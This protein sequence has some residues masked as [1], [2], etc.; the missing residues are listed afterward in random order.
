MDE[1]NNVLETLITDKNRRSYIK[2][3][4]NYSKIIFKGRKNKSELQL[5]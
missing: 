4:S 3:I 5:K 2:E 1:N